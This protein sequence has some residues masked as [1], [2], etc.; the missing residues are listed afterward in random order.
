[1]PLL[2]RRE[3]IGV[4]G[5]ATL[6]RQVRGP[7]LRVSAPAGDLDVRRGAEM[8]VEEAQRA[9]VMFG[10]T[11]D[12]T[13]RRDEA[14]WI[15]I[16]ISAAGGSGELHMNVR[17][18]PPTC[19]R[20]EFDLAPSRGQAWHPALKRFG[21]DSLNKRFQARYRAPMSAGSWCA[22]FAVKCAWEGALRSKAS[23]TAALIAFLE[24]PNAKFDGHKGVPLF[25][26]A[27]HQLVQ[28][29]YGVTGDELPPPD[30]VVRCDW[31]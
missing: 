2:D 31:K 25:F 12:F 24:G 20:N 6:F 14:A 26:S 17:P 11:I 28:P 18:T 3:F 9:A 8:S 30:Q 7:M 22:W 15:G 27:A 10:G 21:A 1:M 5:A 19:H 23:D 16:G 4:L 13:E 29:A